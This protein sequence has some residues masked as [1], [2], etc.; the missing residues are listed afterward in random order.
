MTLAWQ[1]GLPYSAHFGDVYFSA[2]SGLEEARH[3]FLQGNRLAGLRG[4]G[5][6]TVAAPAG[7]H[8]RRAGAGFAYQVSRKSKVFSVLKPACFCMQY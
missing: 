8:P 6:R 3:V 4:A 5:L 1:D 2:D 7:A